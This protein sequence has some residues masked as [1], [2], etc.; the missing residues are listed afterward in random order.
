MSE[1]TA[2]TLSSFPRF[3]DL[4][5]ELRNQIWSNALPEKVDTAL[6]FY[7]TGCWHPL[8]LTPSDPY[9][10]YDDEN[11]NLNLRVEFRHDL[12]NQVH[13]HT[14]LIF[15]NHEAREIAT[16][17]AR[18]QGFVAKENKGH[19]VFG[20]PFNPESDILYVT[21]DDLIEIFTELY[22]LDELYPELVNQN[23][24]A[25]SFV[26]NIAISEETWQKE[27]KDQPEDQFLDGLTNGFPLKT[28]AV[29]VDAPSELQH[30]DHNMEMR[31]HWE[32][33]STGGGD[34]IFDSDRTFQFHG[35]EFAGKEE[36]YR[37]LEMGNRRI[38]KANFPW[39]RTTFKV[40]AALVNKR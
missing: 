1:A 3:M 4:A 31:Q 23:F 13:F 28:L 16:A 18:K 29:I 24:S 38:S 5:P 22:Y 8:Y 32:L 17:W 12:L 26:E 25:R 14:P 21:S 30:V 7:K 37:S 34:Y 6:Y 10:E 2:T 40:Q 20:R 15:V 19:F 9:N 36:L 27:L 35:T 39:I 11:D 33:S